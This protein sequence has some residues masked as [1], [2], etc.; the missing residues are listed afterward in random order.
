W[1]P[2]VY[3]LSVAK[4]V[5]TSPVN[6]GNSVV[7]AVAVTNNGPDPMTRGDTVDLADTLPGPTGTPTPAF[8]VLTVSTSGGSNSNIARGAVTCTGVTVGSAMP[9]STVCS[10]PYSAPSAPQAP[11]GGTRGLDPGETLTI[12]YEQITPNNAAC[13]TITNTATTTDRAT[14]S[15]TT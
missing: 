9:T 10:R 2:C 1:L 6:A 15:G 7:W 11:S 13:A 4:S 5:A 12:T 14:T 3:S 8:K